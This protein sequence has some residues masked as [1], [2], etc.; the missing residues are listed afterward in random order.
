MA[1]R[2]PRIDAYI[3]RAAEFARPIL[4]H[5]RAVVHEAC[6]DVQETIKWSM[7][8]FD[9]HG[10]LAN[11]A[12]FKA[13]AAFGFW[14]GAMIVDAAGRPAEAAMGQ[15]GRLTAVADLPPKRVLIGYVKQAV[16][17]NEQGV[18]AV[19]G[20][21]KP[22]PPAVPSAAFAAAL[23][24]NRKARAGFDAASPGCRREYVE[25]IDEAKREETRDTRIAKAI[26]QLAEGKSLHWRYERPAA[27]APAKKA[28]AKQSKAAT[29]PAGTR[30][31]SARG[32]TR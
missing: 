26:A 8:F 28:P 15:F 21:A 10:P 11:M 6:P 20:T 14:K 23:A 4:E 25:W 13:H 31:R 27:K 30:T 9:H 7:P 12:A 5:L 2:D 24:R 1:S 29:Q 16:K 18:K 22:K 32:R 19:R 3:A 17:L